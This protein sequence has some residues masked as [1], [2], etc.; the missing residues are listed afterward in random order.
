MIGK[1]T[2]INGTYDTSNRGGKAEL[3]QN[4]QL[5]YREALS[6]EGQEKGIEIK[7]ACKKRK[8]PKPDKEESRKCLKGSW[9]P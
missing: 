4:W 8:N 1:N 7:R 5:S 3:G 9:G 6:V 2:N